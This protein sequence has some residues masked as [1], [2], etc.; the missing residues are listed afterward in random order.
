MTILSW[1]LVVAAIALQ[2]LNVAWFIEGISSRRAKS[3]V[4]LVPCVLW[5]IALV[6]RGEGFF[7]A[8]SGMEIGI[9]V[10]AHLLLTIT[11]AAISS[12]FR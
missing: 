8:S 7:V 2:V 1:T 9:V 12:R 11:M 5:Y 4:M 3:Q 10:I 6:I